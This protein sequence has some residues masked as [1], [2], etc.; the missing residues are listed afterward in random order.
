MDAAL[1]R[2]TMK[3][4]ASPAKA[5]TYARFFKTGPGDYGERDKFIGLTVPE[6]RK[7]AKEFQILPFE[8]IEKCLQ[9]PI[10]EE[11]LCALFIL[12]LL[13]KQGTASEKKEA[14]NFYVKNLQHVNNWDLI[15]VTCEHV[16]GAHLE[17]RDK[18]PLYRWA[19]SKNLWERRIAIIS[20]F[21]YIKKNDFDETLKI[22]RMLVQDKHD[23]IQKAVGWML[24]EVGKRSLI[25]QEE[26][27][28]EYYSIMPRTM[29][30]YA[31]ERFP[32]AKRQAYLKNQI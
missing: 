17:L 4:L 15:D 6:V 8:E 7:L 28:K 5:K 14:Y 2:K 19:K 23:L 16:I 1:L 3:R 29:L 26:F 18:K 21:H 12:V 31:I 10:H 13:Y 24:R 32:E 30:R 11:R 9:S 20:T 27:M 22:A 25:I